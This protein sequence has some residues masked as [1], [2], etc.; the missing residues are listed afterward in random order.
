MWGA[1]HQV[2]WNVAFLALYFHLAG[3]ELHAEQLTVSD[4][5]ISALDENLENGFCFVS[6]GDFEER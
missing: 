4:K 2:A 3:D 1:K 5:H 6:V